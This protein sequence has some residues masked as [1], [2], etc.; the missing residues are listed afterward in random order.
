[1]STMRN[2]LFMGI[3]ISFGHLKELYDVIAIKSGVYPLQFSASNCN[4]RNIFMLAE[5][6]ENKC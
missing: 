3:Y 4:F 5:G 1:M 6:T 2:I